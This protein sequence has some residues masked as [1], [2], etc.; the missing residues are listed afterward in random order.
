VKK[1]GEV[2][3]TGV[4]SAHPAGKALDVHRSSYAQHAR[5]LTVSTFA[6][7]LSVSPRTVRDWLAA[8][9]VKAR[10]TV[11]GH[12]RIPRSELDRLRVPAPTSAAA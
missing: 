3:G 7:A 9:E 4:D 12:W 8:G 1:P 6:T 2:G 10:R 11:G 5:D